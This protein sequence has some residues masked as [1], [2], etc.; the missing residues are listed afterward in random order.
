M[1]VRNQM[2]KNPVTITKDFTVSEALDLFSKSPFHRLPVVDSTNHLIG[3]ITEGII[4]AN[5][6]S[7]ATSLSMFELNYL[8]SKTTVESI[9]VT[10]VITIGPDE[11]LEKAADIMRQ[12]SIACLPVV[13]EEGKLLGII[14]EKDIFA[15]FIEILGYY[16]EGSRIVVEVD[17]DKPGILADLSRVLADAGANISHLVVFREDAV[18]V[19]IR[20][21][22]TDADKLVALLE[23]HG[24]KVTDARVNK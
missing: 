15:S 17:E 14:T 13:D 8:L 5:T 11:L 10:K 20:A 24:Y 3:L 12:H 6:P 1:Y 19:V 23:E 4:R 9:M 2:T 21:D 7:Q 16:Q 18:S 22:D